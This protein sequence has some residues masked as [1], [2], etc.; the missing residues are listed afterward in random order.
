MSDLFAFEV[1]TPRCKA[2]QNLDER[3]RQRALKQHLTWVC[4]FVVIGAP[5]IIASNRPV[6]WL[7]WITVLSLAFIYYV[8]RSPANSNIFSALKTHKILFFIGALLPTTAI[9]QALAGLSLTPDAALSGAMR[10]TGYLLFFLLVLEL[11]TK[12]QNAEALLWA[13]FLATSAH[14][15]WA[16]F[17]LAVLNDFAIWGEKTAYAGAATGV[18]INRN[19]FAM[20]LG[21]GLIAGIPLVI[22]RSTKSDVLSAKG[23][24][25]LCLCVCLGVI[26]MCIIATQ[27]RMGILST[28]VGCLVCIFCLQR[29]KT[30]QSVLITIGIFLAG[31]VVMLL[32]WG[33]DVF[34]RLVFLKLDQIDRS[35]LYLQMIDMIIQRPYIGFGLNSFQLAFEQFQ[36]PPM[37]MNLV[38]EYGHSSY[39]TNWLEYGLIIGSLPIA[40]GLMVVCRLIKKNQI[41]APAIASLSLCAVHSTVDFG[42][43]IPANMFVFLTL[44]GIGLASSDRKGVDQ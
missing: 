25:K 43:E 8:M 15:I 4:G 33:G 23:L 18:F 35:T 2:A 30:L 37:T 14:A 39:L 7:F 29:H 9:F 42:L 31:L 44:I 34:Q 5:L 16:I 40:L 10:L 27:S 3:N 17:A 32:F 13:I 1:H 20:F 36:A 11:A 38:W 22:A 41:T 28:C 26:A 12:K 21:M 24:E 19:T 6:F